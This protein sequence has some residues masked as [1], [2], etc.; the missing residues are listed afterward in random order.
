MDHSRERL[1]VSPITVLARQSAGAAF[2]A[3]AAGVVAVEVLVLVLWAG[4][5]SSG[6]TASQAAR[7]GLIAWEWIH[8][9]LIHVP[10]G[11]VAFTPPALLLLPLWLLRRAAR[12]CH[13]DPEAGLDSWA[14]AT[15]ATL[16]LA[17]PYGAVAS[18]IA[19]LSSTQGIEIEA[20]SAAAAPLAVALVGAGS[21][22][23][24]PVLR[25]SLQA[26][27]EG[28]RV[29]LRSGMIAVA[30][31]LVSGALVTT[32]SLVWHFGL[33]SE[34]STAITTTVTGTAGLLLLGV[35]ILPAAAVWTAAVAA[36]PGFA[37]GA[38][39]AVTASAV[40]LGAVPAIALA[41]ALPGSGPAPFVLRLLPLAMVAAGLLCGSHLHKR[42]SCV[43]L[44]NRCGWAVIS[45]VT[46]G[47]VM[48]G[49]SALSGGSLAPGRLAVLGPSPWR[50]GLGVME[51]IGL[52]AAV[53]V[54]ALHVLA[55]RRAVRIQ[56]EA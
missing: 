16:L 8:H 17:L 21:W 30:T 54:I 3:A 51:E 4:D 49:L 12:R 1:D 13:P 41:A 18:V 19:L 25:R 22:C 36:G 47:A 50:V 33:A 39:T 15:R 46:A 40:H 35:S 31:L 38:H 48:A 23:C 55:K 26:R 34:Y 52:V 7:G 11:T 20:I 24:A 6:S 5:A 2:R 28:F 32:G 9:A 14:E 27:S 43:P 10:G 37:F 53:V 44:A 45:G 56:P 29:A 42:L